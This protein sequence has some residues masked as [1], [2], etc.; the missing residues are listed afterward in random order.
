MESGL[1]DT[2]NAEE[3]VGACA[4]TGKVVGDGILAEDPLEGG[5]GPCGRA[6]CLRLRRGRAAVT[7]DHDK[8]V[9]VSGL[10][11]SIVILVTT[12]CTTGYIHS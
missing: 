6:L 4:A 3:S 9:K 11:N 7:D 10:G 12:F 8:C 5:V 2:S 1:L